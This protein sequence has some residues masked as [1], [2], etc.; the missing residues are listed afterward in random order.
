MHRTA[1][2][3]GFAAA[4]TVV[5][6][7]LDLGAQEF[8]R[9]F[10][11]REYLPRLVAAPREPVT[12]VK[13]VVPVETPSRFGSA[14]EGEADIGVSLPVVVLSGSSPDDAIVLGVE[15]GV[16]ARFNLE[17]Q[18]R[19][20]ITS[21]W[22]FTLPV[23]FLRDGHWLQVR[24]FHTSAHL[25]DEYAERF[26]VERIVYARDALE[27]TFYLN[28]VSPLG[29]YGGARWGFRV[30]PPEHKRWAI[31]TGLEYEDPTVHTIRSYG[32][33]DVELD[34]Q[35]SWRPRLNLQ[36]GVRVYTPSNRRTVRMG[37]EFLTGPSPQGQFDG[38]RTTHIA[39]GATLEF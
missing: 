25:G 21:D 29:V 27:A 39:I 12:S 3:W 23:V 36:V 20:L 34:Q 32:A 1:F 4:I 15:G 11:G 8:Q 10:P 5:C 2:V 28:P 26:S 33:V 9:F 16:F 22:V 19:D 13:L 35:Y 18:E 30:D 24:Y 37:L 7:P 38:V 17:T 6:T 14:L 31:R